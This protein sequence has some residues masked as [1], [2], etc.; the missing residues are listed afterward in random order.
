[1]AKIL[2]TPRSLT[3]GGDPALELLKKAGYQVVFCT[4]GKAPDE[5]ELERLLPGCVGWLAG[6]EKIGGSR[7]SRSASPSRSC[8]P[9]PRATHG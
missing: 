5:A 3:R 9:S 1:M 8:A 4:P 7:S 2:V 6:V